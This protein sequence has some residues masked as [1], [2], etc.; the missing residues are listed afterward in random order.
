MKKIKEILHSYSDH[1]T[2]TDL[3]LTEYV[4]DNET[5]SIPK[6]QQYFGL[7]V[8]E[9][10][11]LT[12]D[13]GTYTKNYEPK[14]Y[15]GYVLIDD[16]V[17]SSIDEPLGLIF[18]VVKESNGKIDYI[19]E[20]FSGVK[21][22]VYQG[23]PEEIQKDEFLDFKEFQLRFDE[24]RNNPLAIIPKSGPFKLDDQFKMLVARSLMGREEEIKTILKDGEA[25]AKKEFENDLKKCVS[26]AYEKA[27]VDNMLLEYEKK[28]SLTNK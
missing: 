6:D 10:Y 1:Y 25:Y 26:D 2:N 14:D 11:F 7:I 8:D 4:N 23:K 20:I 22:K 15:S 12:P 24:V 3:L 16:N 17:I 21:M 13:I 9:V 18:K 27:Y 5:F 19:E 28:Y